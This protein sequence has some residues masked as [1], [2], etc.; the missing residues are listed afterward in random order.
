M[1]HSSCALHQLQCNETTSEQEWYAA[2]TRCRP[3]EG[4]NTSL[5]R[6]MQGA[7][8]IQYDDGDHEAALYL[9]A[10]EWRYTT[11]AED[12]TFQSSLQRRR[13]EEDAMTKA[14]VVRCLQLF[15]NTLRQHAPSHSGAPLARY[16][17][18]A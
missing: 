3:A 2:L 9:N 5:W 14:L 8:S 16:M 13:A 1:A 17:L 18:N 10:E 4:L 7:F 15:C 6:S 12:T 11:D